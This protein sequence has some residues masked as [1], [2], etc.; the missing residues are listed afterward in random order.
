MVL[1]IGAGEV[2]FRVIDW[3]VLT[4]FESVDVI[5]SRIWHHSENQFGIIDGGWIKIRAP[6]TAF[7]NMI[8][9]FEGVE[10]VFEPEFDFPEDTLSYPAK[11][12]GLLILLE[13]TPDEYSDCT[14]YGIIIQ[15]VEDLESDMCQKV[16]LEAGS[17]QIFKRVG[18]FSTWILT[19]TRLLFEDSIQEIV[20]V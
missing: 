2:K 16:A 4:P 7:A 10:R 20:L 17:G 5:D 1:G 14:L 6:L 8:Q 18:Y 3:E 19:R 11:D 12:C 13:D 15:R 9:N